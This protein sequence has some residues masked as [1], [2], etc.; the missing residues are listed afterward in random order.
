VLV[1]GCPLDWSVDAFLLEERLEIP[2][3]LIN[4]DHKDTG[5]VNVGE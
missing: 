3:Q 1:V 4:I 5:D 2:G